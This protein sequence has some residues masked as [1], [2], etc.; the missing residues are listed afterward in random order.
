MPTNARKKKTDDRRN[1]W[2]TSIKTTD[3]SELMLLETF[4]IISS[5]TYKTKSETV[6][7]IRAFRSWISS[8]GNEEV[9]R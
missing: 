1:S 5:T 7:S 3:I 6:I 9:H 2:I 4:G 8:G